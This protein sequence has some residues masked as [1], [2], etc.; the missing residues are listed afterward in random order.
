MLQPS[1]V[2]P[3]P[4]LPSR[5]PARPYPCSIADGLLRNLYRWVSH[6]GSALHDPSLH[7]A[8]LGLQHKLFLQLCAEMRRLGATIVSANLNTITLATGKTSH[9][10]AVGWVGGRRASERASVGRRLRGTWRAALRCCCQ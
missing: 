10:A 8:L 3:H 4:I 1:P 7:A 6:P 2:T 5:P 9:R